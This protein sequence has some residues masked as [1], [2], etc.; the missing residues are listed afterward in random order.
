[1]RIN[2]VKKVKA[3]ELIKVERKYGNLEKKV[4]RKAP[5]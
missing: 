1:M 3:K 2:F 5:R 4:L